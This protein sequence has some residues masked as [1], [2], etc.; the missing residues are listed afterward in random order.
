MDEKSDLCQE[1]MSSDQS[2]KVKIEAIHELNRMN[3]AYKPERVEVKSKLSLSV[4]LRKFNGS[5]LVR[6]E[7]I[8]ETEKVVSFFMKIGSGEFCVEL[9][10]VMQ[11]TPHL[12]IR[13]FG[14]NSFMLC[15]ST[16]KPCLA[17]C[18]A[19]GCSLKF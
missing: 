18:N 17:E 1:T 12:K 8:D 6:R 5:E 3:G 7:E 15:L 9:F 16:F 11:S 14:N 10:C 19:L 4:L 2:M 13:H